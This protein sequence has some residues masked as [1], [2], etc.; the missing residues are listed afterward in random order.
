M[1]KSSDA[2]F[3]KDKPNGYSYNDFEG[4]RASS[5]INKLDNLNSYE[6]FG[7]MGHSEKD[8][9]FISSDLGSN[10]DFSEAETIEMTDDY[11][12]KSTYSVMENVVDKERKNEKQIVLKVINTVSYKVDRNDVE[13]IVKGYITKYNY[14]NSLLNEI[15]NI[16]FDS[17]PDAGTFSLVVE[18]NT[19][20]A[21]NFDADAAEVQT[22]IVNSGTDV[23]VTGDFA[24]GFSIRFNETG[25]FAQIAEDSNTL[26]IALAPIVITY[27]TTREGL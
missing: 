26:T 10:L 16:S 7:R 2:R 20:A 19:T 15:Q 3:V 18:G 8:L 1:N 6:R 25:D 11:I 14:F 13:S 24:T 12:A 23:T 5:V 17:I 27:S 22:A 4:N 9:V 21:I